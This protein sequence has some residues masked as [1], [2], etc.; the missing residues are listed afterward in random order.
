MKKVSVIHIGPQKSATTWLYQCIESHL[1]IVAARQDSIHYFDMFHHRGDNWYHGFF[2]EDNLSG[3]KLVDMTPSYLR[4]AKAPKRIAEYNSDIKIILCLRNPIERAFS[5][6]WHEKSRNNINYVFG[7]CL[8]NYDLFQSWIETGFYAHH[9]LSYKKYFSDSN[10]LIQ[11]FNDLRE[12]PGAF[13]KEFLRFIGVST[14]HC[15][16]VLNRKSNVAQPAINSKIQKIKSGLKE[17][18]II[19]KIVTLKNMLREMEIVKDHSDLTKK[20][21]EKVEKLQNEDNKLKEELLMIYS[22]EIQRLEMITN[23]RF[24]HWKK[25]F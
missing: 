7:D 24:D 17:K 18:W 16:A 1:E 2:Q 13:L 4:S 9:I 22:E 6:Y 14:E 11:D 25:I 3:K 20:A 5:H 8:S 12:N 15:P 23:K 19:K 21:K 10:I